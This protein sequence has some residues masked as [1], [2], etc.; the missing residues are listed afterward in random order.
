MSWSASEH[1][2]R[3]REFRQRA[4]KCQK[5]ANGSASAKFGDC[6]MLLAKNYIVLAELE[7][8]Y[9][10]RQNPSLPEYRLVAAE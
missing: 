3:A 7:E 10:A 1:L 4:V 9:V 8:D 5:L 2:A 6:Y